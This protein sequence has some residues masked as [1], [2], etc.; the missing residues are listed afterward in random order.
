MINQLMEDVQ[1]SA[2]SRN[3]AINKV[4]IKDI[5]H[6]VQIHDVDLHGQPYICPSI[7][8]F[9]MMVNLRADQKGTHMSRFIHLLTAQQLSL[10]AAHM[11]VLLDKMVNQL[12]SEQGFIEATFPYFLAKQAPISKT[13]S[14]MD[15]QVTLKGALSDQQLNTTI[16][17]VVP[18]A[19]LCP[20]SKKIAQYGAHNQRSHVTL[21]VQLNAPLAL[22]PLIR[23]AEQQASCE[24]YGA[25]KR[26]DEK[27]VTEYAY[28][29]PKFVEDLVRDIA[30][31]LNQ[32]PQITYFKVASENFESIHNHS[33]Y[34]EIEGRPQKLKP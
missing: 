20:C 27:F 4:G 19:S 32:F 9:E 26:P 14:L 31:Q 7:A 17:L 34:A 8:N 18:V 25:L 11:P 15:Y 22:T 5:K 29:N 28:E 3:L 1:A 6:P 23:V 30:N 10:S 21:E 13:V 16:I 33:A 24:L 2:D 12:E